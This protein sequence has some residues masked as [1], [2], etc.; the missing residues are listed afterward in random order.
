MIAEPMTLSEMTVLATDEILLRNEI[1][2]IEE[3]GTR[4]AASKRIWWVRPRQARPSRMTPRDFTSEPFRREGRNL[5][6]PRSFCKIPYLCT[7]N[8]QSIDPATKHVDFASERHEIFPPHHLN[9]N[10]LV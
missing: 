9:G 5:L 1:S 7:D 10:A 2:G 8:S 4:R 3:E 6:R